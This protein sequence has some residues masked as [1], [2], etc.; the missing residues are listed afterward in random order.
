M[1]GLWVVVLAGCALDPLAV[2]HS[3]PVADVTPAATV[4]S[5]DVAVGD[6]PVPLAPPTMASTSPVTSPFPATPTLSPT[7]AFSSLV[8]SPTPFV[9]AADGYCQRTFGPE[10][11][12]RF[13]AH[14][15]SVSTQTA[16]DHTDVVFQFD[17][18]DGVLH[19]AASCRWAGAWL[20]TDVG[21][22]AAPGSAFIALDLPDWAHDDAFT[23]SIFTDTRVLTASNAFEHNQTLPDPTLNPQPPTPMLAFAA[24]SLDSRGA[25]LGIG[26]PEPRPFTVRIEDERVIVSIATGDAAQSLPTPDPLGEAHGTPTQ[27]QQDLVFVQDHALFRLDAQGAAQPISTTLGAISDLAVDAT[28]TRL[29]V[30]A[31]VDPNNSQRAALWS[32]NADGTNAR[33]LADVGGCAEP[34]LMGNGDIAYVAPAPDAA[35]LPTV[36]TIPAT[37]GVAVPVHAT[38]QWTRSAPRW[39]A[40]RRLVYRA[41]NA[42]GTNVL[43]LNENGVEREVSARLLT[44]T[45][46]RGVGAF[47]VEPQAD[48]IA[49]QALHAADAGSDLVIMRADGGVL[50]TE[51]RG[52]QQHP[53]GFTNEGLLYLTIECPS[54][55]VQPY[56]LRR[57]TANGTSETLL[58]G[59]TTATISAA[60]V[61]GNALLYVRT[62]ATDDGST[63]GSELWLLDG[64]DATRVRVRRS[65]T[66]MSPTAVGITAR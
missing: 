50:A 7:A 4:P 27:A 39:L 13:S 8:P 33:M 43:F 6:S 11:G 1:A 66:P 61:F 57:R 54:S 40:R 30:C 63:D 22:L 52:W 55:T 41:A 62:A 21:A 56:A 28:G 24:N 5:R 60:R 16:A 29:V 32:L 53:L 2:P 38:D 65:Q 12:A 9:R 48:L 44:G 18:V 51:Q 42:D 45:A 25:L 26:L 34:T 36:W 49:V 47:V 15:R 19:G 20:H 64:G 3:S 31:P 58:A 14:L 59:S 17:G 10:D 46:Y 23:T 37:A 35:A